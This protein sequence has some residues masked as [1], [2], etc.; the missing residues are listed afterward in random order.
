MITITRARCFCRRCLLAG[1]VAIGAILSALPH[2]FHS[3]EE[4][5]VWAVLPMHHQPDHHEERSGGSPVRTIMVEVASASA[6]DVVG[7]IN[8]TLPAVSARIEG[9][10]R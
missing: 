2:A 1:A 8:V 5:P 6:T 9:E 10:A 7:M 4:H 3:P